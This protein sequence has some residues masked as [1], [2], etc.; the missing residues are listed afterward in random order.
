[1]NGQI[2]GG[3]FKGKGARVKCPCACIGLD[4]RDHRVISLFD[5]SERDGSDVASMW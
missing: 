3:G 5:L 2:V 4:S 1:M